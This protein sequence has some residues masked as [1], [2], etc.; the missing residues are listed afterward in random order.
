MK[1][2]R[3]I[4]MTAAGVVL[5]GIG[6]GFIKA[7]MLGTDPFTGAVTGLCRLLGMGYGSLYV[8]INAVLLLTVWFT[9]RHYVGIATLINVVGMG[10]I[11]QFTSEAVLKGVGAAGLSGIVVELCLFF[12]GMMILCAGTSLYFTADLGVS[13]YD[14]AALI[15][16][17]KKGR[18]LKGCRIGTDLLCV[19]VAVILGASIGAGTV[20]TA[21]FMGPFIEFFNR[22]LAEPLLS[23]ERKSHSPMIA[24]GGKVC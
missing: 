10:Y 11:V 17:D 19:I 16:R 24:N 6:C 18:S 2:R 12:I 7:A 1:D 4:I 8:I 14:A 5:S 3:R 23:R 21:F 20:A 9:D 22:H 13:T 15:L